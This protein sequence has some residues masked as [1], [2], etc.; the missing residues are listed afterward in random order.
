MP[1]EPEGATPLDPDE[2]EG[3]IPVG[4]LSRDDLNAWEQV[5]VVAGRRW[6]LGIR[7][8]TDRVLSERFL[9]KLHRKMFASVWKWSG[10]YRKS[11]RNIG[12]HWPQVATAMLDAIE[13]ARTWT[14]EGAWSPSELAARFHHRLVAIHPFPNGNGRWSRLATDALMHALRQP[15]PMWGASIPGASRRLEYLEALREADRGRF[16][17]L[18]KFVWR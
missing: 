6:A 15:L 8:A 14:I 18:I 17:R 12:V 2:L 4:I 3:L 5:G 13:D 16:D 11:D 9:R 7:R 10:T 1:Q